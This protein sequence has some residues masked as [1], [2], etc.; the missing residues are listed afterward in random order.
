LF[1]RE[2]AIALISV[3]AD[4]LLGT[5]IVVIAARTPQAGLNPD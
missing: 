1:Y 3:I 2:R 4:T 5:E